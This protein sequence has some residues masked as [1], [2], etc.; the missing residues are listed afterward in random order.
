MARFVGAALLFVAVPGLIGW[1]YLRFYHTAAV[2]EAVLYPEGIVWRDAEGWNGCQWEDVRHVHRKEVVV[3]GLVQARHVRLASGFGWDVTLEHTLSD[4]ALLADTVQAR[5]ADRQIPEALDLFHHGET[6][7]FGP[8]E[9]GPHGLTVA[10]SF[11]PWAD[12]KR[13]DLRKGH[14]VLHPSDGRAVQAIPFGDIPDFLVFLK[15]L[16]AAHAPTPGPVA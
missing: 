2:R 14:L 15:V 1:A 7:E 6:V 9:V 4:W 10:G 13:I 3:K 12:L 11:F 5:V 16:E 8:M